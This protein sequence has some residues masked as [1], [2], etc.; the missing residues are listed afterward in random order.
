M[1][2]INYPYQITKRPQF[3]YYKN[4]PLFIGDA[5]T[6][7]Y[8]YN[9]EDHDSCDRVDQDTGDRVDNDSC[10]GVDN[11]TCDGVDKDT[12]NRVDNDYCDGVDNATCDVVDQDTGDRVD[13]GSYKDSDAAKNNM[14]DIM[15]FNELSQG[16][17]MKWRNIFFF[18]INLPLCYKLKTGE[19]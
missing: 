10:D 13:N 17:G 5:G 7:Y 9:D 2:N 6:T 19:L 11:D 15:D 12:G 16:E 1:N 3:R 4:T 14:C 18:F 8:K